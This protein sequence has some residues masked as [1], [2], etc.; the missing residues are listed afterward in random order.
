MWNRKSD[1]SANWNGRF[2]EDEIFR[3]VEERVSERLLAINQL[4]LTDF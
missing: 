4:L 2:R 3:D 1:D